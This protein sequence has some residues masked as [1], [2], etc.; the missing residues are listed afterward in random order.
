MQAFKCERCGAP[1]EVSP[2]TIIAICPYCGYPNH[3]SGSIDTE[4]IYIA[5]SLKK[6]AIYQAFMKRV[7]KDMDLRRL[8]DDIQVVE[9][10]GHYVPY[11]RGRVSLTGEVKYMKRETECHTVTDSEGNTREECHTVE[12]HYHEFIDRTMYLM[13]SA[14]R[15]VTDF[16][17]ND[18][19]EHYKKNSPKLKPLKDLNEDEWQ[20]I[21]L[22]ILNTEIDEQ[23]AKML[24]KEDAVDVVREEYKAKSDEIE[25]FRCEPSE[26]E[27][28]RLVLLP[29]WTVYYKYGNSIFKVAFSGWDGKD[30]AATEPMTALR[31]AM[32]IGGIIMGIVIGG[33]G[34][35]AISSGAAILPLIAGAGLAYYS[36]SKVLAGTRIER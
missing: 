14:R 33:V 32:Y 1:L 6:D 2:E 15:Q 28:V 23:Q 36:G 21:K 12:R 30:V 3:I 34:A 22:E 31:R 35:A 19:I 17:I 5:P 16:G 20:K 4:H 26:P 27:D 9:I 29:I 8:K 11:W 10:E 24:M 13:G 18:I 25:Y 7:E